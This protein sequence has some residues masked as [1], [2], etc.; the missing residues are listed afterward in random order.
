MAGTMPS[1]AAANTA[2]A[3]ANA[4]RGRA[5]ADLRSGASDV[6]GILRSACLPEGAALRRITLVRLLSGQE[7]WSKRQARST[8]RSILDALGYRN[9]ADERRIDQLTIMWLID[10]RA[11]G[12]RVRAFADALDPKENPPWRG[13]PFAVPGSRTT[14]NMN[15]NKVHS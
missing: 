11:G 2:R 12:R 1:L 4:Q 7:G 13:F 9:T 15:E 3:E 8:V 14:G 5:L 6:P 10:A